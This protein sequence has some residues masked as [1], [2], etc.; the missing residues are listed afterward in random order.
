MRLLSLTIGCL[1]SHQSDLRSKKED[2]RR[3]KET[4]QRQIDMMREQGLMDTSTLTDTHHVVHT[5]DLDSLPSDSAGRSVPG[6]RRSASADFNHG[7]PASQMEMDMLSSE[8]RGMPRRPRHSVSSPQ[9][10]SAAAG[11]GKQ[12]IP[13]HLMSTRNEQRLGGANMQKLPMKLSSGVAS[14]SSSSSSSA[15]ASHHRQQ[16]QQQQ[17]PRTASLSSL[18][19]RQGGASPASVTPTP[20]Q[21]Q[22]MITRNQNSRSTPSNLALVM[23]LAEPSGRGR[24]AAAQQAHAGGGAG[25]LAPGGTGSA[26]AAPKPADEGSPDRVIY[27]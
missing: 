1:R 3:E 20:Q 6:H 4:L 23:K 8:A 7:A 27:F 10:H 13:M 19:A 14:S 26:S 24:G 5:F 17:H 2:L 21:A 22:G 11:G 18:G 16:Q 25:G 15:A 12:N 9:S